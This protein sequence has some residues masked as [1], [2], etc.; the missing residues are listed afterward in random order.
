MTLS[1][2][3]GQTNS[4][5][6][7]IAFLVNPLSPRSNQNQFSPNTFPAYII[8]RQGYESSLHSKRFCA[9]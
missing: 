1:N 9:V 2:A 6:N 4:L 5:R 7:F 8:K 3:D